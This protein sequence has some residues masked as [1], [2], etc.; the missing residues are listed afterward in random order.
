MDFVHDQLAMG[1][2]LR[3]LTVIDTFSRYAPVVDPRLAYRGADVVATLERVTAA[4]RC[5]S[6]SLKGW[7]V[8][9]RSLSLR[10]PSLQSVHA[11]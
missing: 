2:K 5:R 1:T 9:A 11:G 8:A 10:L 3:I 4:I 7:P 6:I